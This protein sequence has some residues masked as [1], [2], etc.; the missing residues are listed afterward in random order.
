[1]IEIVSIGACSTAGKRNRKDNMITSFA[2]MI[3]A[4]QLLSCIL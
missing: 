2:F 1:M 3:Q 4:L